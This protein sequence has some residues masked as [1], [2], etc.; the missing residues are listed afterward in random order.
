MSTPF[1][2]PGH[3]GQQPAGYPPPGYNSP[4]PAGQPYPPQQGFPNQPPHPGFAP[5]QPGS[6][7]YGQH[8]GGFGPPYSGPPRKKSPLIWFLIGGGLLVLAGIV[9]LIF[10]LTSDDSDS[11]SQPA[12]S[13][14]NSASSSETSASNASVESAEDLAEAYTAAV[15]TGDFGKVKSLSCSADHKVVDELQKS[16]DPQSILK[17]IQGNIANLPEAQRPEGLAELSADDISMNFKVLKLTDYGSSRAIA[18]MQV[19]INGVSQEIAQAANL[20]LSTDKAQLFI[21]KSDNTWLA[22]GNKT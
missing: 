22:C 14:N 8:P 4:P 6:P 11:T 20:A 5:Q 9:I 19:K 17:R 15:S 2:Q 13:T 1:N 21:E 10:A 16:I 7:G 3:Q 12:A 18:T